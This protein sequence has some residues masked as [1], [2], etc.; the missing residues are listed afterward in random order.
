MRADT[1]PACPERRRILQLALPAG[2][3]GDHCAHDPGGNG[4]GDEEERKLPT[5]GTVARNQ[6]TSIESALVALV[7][8]VVCV[9]EERG[10]GLAP[11]ARR[12]VRGPWGDPSWS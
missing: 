11:V 1:R 12:G 3:P 9:M 7:C 4:P 8:L 2:H 5:T 6:P 10:T